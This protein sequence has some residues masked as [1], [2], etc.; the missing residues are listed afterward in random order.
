MRI[1]VL[2]PDPDYPEPW[3]WAY[4]VEAA[5]LASAGAEV[6]P[7]PWT[8]RRELSAFDLV[9]PLVAWGYHLDYPRWIDFLEL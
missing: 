9:L 7:V 2:V 4:D 5:A 8:G 6:E 3:S 1:A